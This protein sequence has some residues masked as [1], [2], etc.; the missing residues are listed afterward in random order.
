MPST[1][2]LT[3]SR[4]VMFSGGATPMADKKRVLV[5]RRE[6]D[7]TRK[8]FRVDLE[9]L[10]KYGLSDLDIPLKPGDVVWVP[11]AWY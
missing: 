1:R 11:E 6:A 4:A 9:K 10:G 3:V 2:D 7:G 5:T 8:K